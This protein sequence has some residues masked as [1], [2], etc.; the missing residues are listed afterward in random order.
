MAVCTMSFFRRR[1]RRLRDF[2]CIPWLPPPLG[3][4]T[5]PLPVTRNRL[6]AAFLVFIFGMTLPTARPEPRPEAVG[7]ARWS[8]RA[9]LSSA[10]GQGGRERIGHALYPGLGPGARH[11][12]PFAT[13][14]VLAHVEVE[15]GLRL[16]AARPR[17]DP[18]ARR[19]PEPRQ[20]ALG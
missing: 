10:S 13:K 18:P 3:R 6:A 9:G 8:E 14:H 2:S 12:H 16:R 5:R 19:R 7:G 11:G 17:D 1:R 4:R 15:L 20:V